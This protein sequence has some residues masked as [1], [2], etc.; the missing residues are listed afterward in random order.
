MNCFISAAVLGTRA[1]AS[2]AAA[3][4]PEMIAADRIAPRTAS[5][6]DADTTK[7]ERMLCVISNLHASF[8]EVSTRIFDN[9]PHPFFDAN[10]GCGVAAPFEDTHHADAR[11]P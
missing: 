5:P 2:A 10:Y 9:A 11:S 3:G 8:A 4:L 1:R 7:A 6:V